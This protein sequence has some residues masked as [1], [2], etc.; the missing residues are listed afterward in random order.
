VTRTMEQAYRT[1]KAVTYP[2]NTVW[3][4]AKPVG[5]ALILS[6]LVLW[7]GRKATK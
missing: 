1:P 2:H 5:A 4:V 6:V 7:L 3:T